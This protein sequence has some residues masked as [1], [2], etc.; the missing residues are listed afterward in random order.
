[1][2][3][4][5]LI[6]T[7]WR[8]LIRPPA[9]ISLGLLTLGGFLTGIIFWGGFNTAMEFTNTE[10]FCISC[11]EMRDNV[12]KELQQT[13]HWSNRSGVRATCSD[14]HVP[15]DWTHKIAR[16]MQAS[17]EFWAHIFGTVNTRE[18]F[19]EKRLELAQNEWAR[20]DAN[21]SL[22]CRNCHDYDSM[23]WANMSDTAR[24]YME[25]AAK[26]NQ[27]C[28]DCHKGIAH[29][30]PDNLNIVNP[31]LMRLEQQA[32]S[33]SLRQGG[34][35]FTVKSV[36]VFEDESLQTPAGSL[37]LA[38]AVEVVQAN[39]DKVHL[40][41]SAWRKEKGFGRVLYEDFGRNI[42]EAVLTRET[43]QNAMLMETGDA[44]TDDLT[45]LDWREVKVT[46]WAPAGNFVADIEPMWEVASGIYDSACSVCHAQPDPAHFDSNSW[47]GQFTGMVGFTNMDAN[48]QA[49]VLKY[50]QKHSS[51]YSDKSH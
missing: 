9:K 19:L 20:F 5:G 50:L 36:D 37:E 18:K 32:T 2:S 13:V 15:H 44:R 48:T 23:N 14:C 49:L 21:N 47:P 39:R 7:F 31:A 22:E 41:V 1:M 28:I 3:L 38:T 34:T 25:R 33:A 10:T 42:R 26:T 17:K 45:G 29:D 40:A 46:L 35:Y 16:K 11:H 43:A 12:Y 6:T 4:K 30:L 8:A 27:S 24:F 51:D